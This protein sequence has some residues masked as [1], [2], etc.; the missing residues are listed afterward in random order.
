MKTLVS[1]INITKKPAES[2]Y[3]YFLLLCFL[4]LHKRNKK[5]L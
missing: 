3:F 5:I 1:I 2:V 4:K